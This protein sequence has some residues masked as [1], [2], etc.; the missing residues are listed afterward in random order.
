MTPPSSP[1]T[2]PSL[3]S[4]LSSSVRHGFNVVCKCRLDVSSGQNGE[5]DSAFS[6]SVEDETENVDQI[7]GEHIRVSDDTEY[8]EKDLI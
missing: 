8:L 7:T 6:D 4:I 2:F 1:L 5:E 3:R